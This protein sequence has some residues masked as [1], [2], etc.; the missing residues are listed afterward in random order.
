M[1]I[2]TVRLEF[3]GSQGGGLSARLELP[4]KTP[5][6]Y[7]LFAHCF[8]CSK[9]FKPIVRIS[10][11]LARTGIAVLRFDF[12]GLGESDGEFSETN[13][14]SNLDDLVTAAHF[15]EQ[16]YETPKLLIGHSLGGAAV[17]A[18]AER[19]PAARA[20][21]TISA[22][23]DTAH[24]KSAL[25]RRAPKLADEDE[26]TISLGGQAVRL[27]R[28]L[29]EDLDG[30]SME[31]HIKRLGR[32]LLILHSP[33]DEIVSIEH[34]HKIFELAAHPKS[35]V[36]LDRSDHLLLENRNDADYVAAL[37]ASWAPRY[38]SDDAEH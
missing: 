21:A 37:L 10:R 13:F 16:E 15:L 32:P 35:F 17:L 36:S 20:I 4:A 8:T 6:A 23:S 7:A 5:K 38:L 26:A 34:G 14:S 27:S 9:D 12:T 33:D 29:L 18:V 31:G 30:H 1:S 3:A 22:P 28:Q 25:M 2:K 24:L 11:E 19:L